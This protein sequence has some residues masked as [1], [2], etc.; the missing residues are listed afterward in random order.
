MARDGEKLCLASDGREASS[1]VGFDSRQAREEE[2]VVACGQRTQAEVEVVSGQR[3][4]G[5]VVA[6]A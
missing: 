1:L 2:E 4:Q 6:E 3:I 5:G